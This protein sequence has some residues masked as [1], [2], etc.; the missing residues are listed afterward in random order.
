MLTI[1]SILREA[2][3]AYRGEDNKSEGIEAFAVAWRIT[4]AC[5]C[6]R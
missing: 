2:E 3:E 1:Q 4:W 6:P 5:S